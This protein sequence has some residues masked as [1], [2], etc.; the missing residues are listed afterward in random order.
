MNVE[1]IEVKFS[2]LPEHLRKEVV[3]FIEF[4]TNKYQS[5]EGS[6]TFSFNW[7]GGLS[8]LKGEYSSVE[9]QHKSAE[10]R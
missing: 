10:W 8:E 9:L 2:K 5:P 4:L 7:E 6:G 3:D 1:T